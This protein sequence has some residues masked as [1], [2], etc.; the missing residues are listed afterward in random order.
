M[1]RTVIPINGDRIPRRPD[2]STKIARRGSPANAVAEFKESGLVAG[3]F[4]QC[5]EL[6]VVPALADASR[7]ASSRVLVVLS[8]PSGIFMISH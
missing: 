1:A 8:G 4:H 5:P 2:N 6:L 7:T 3:H